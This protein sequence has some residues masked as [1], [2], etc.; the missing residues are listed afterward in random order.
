[1]GNQSNHITIK[2]ANNSVICLAQP[3]G[4]FRNS[5]HYRLQVG[6]RAA[7]H[8]QDLARSGLL[9]LSLSNFTRLRVDGL[10]QLRERVFGRRGTPFLKRSRSA[11][12]A[13]LLR[14][15]FG[16]GFHKIEARSPDQI[17]QAMI[18]VYS[19]ER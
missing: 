3:R 19:A 16:S 5:V 8:P 1:M 17:A 9:F 12:S 6:R 7:N 2:A 13:R 11:L 14:A 18:F 4:T 15:F 10:F